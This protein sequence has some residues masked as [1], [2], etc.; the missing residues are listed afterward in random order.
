[1]KRGLIQLSDKSNAYPKGIVEDV[2][3]KINDLIFP[4]DFYV[5]D[6]GK[7]DET[8]PI[9]L[10]RPFLRT[11][12]TKIDARSGTLTMEFDDEI[13][14]F[15]IYDSIKCPNDNNLVYSI[16][17]TDYLVQDIVE[18]ERTNKHLVKEK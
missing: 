15:N 8:T 12:K 16:D 3:V 1:M 14:K 18:L 17:V 13:A 4:V 10:G 7:S 5:L 2:L 6:M 9:L 11:S